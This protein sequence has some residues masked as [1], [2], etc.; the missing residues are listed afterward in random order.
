MATNSMKTH[1]KSMRTRHISLASFSDREDGSSRLGI[2]EGCILDECTRK[3]R[4]C[5][6]KLHIAFFLLLLLLLLLLPLVVLGKPNSC[7]SLP[8]DKGCP[9]WLCTQQ[10]SLLLVHTTPQWGRLLPC[11]MSR[12]WQWHCGWQL[13][14]RIPTRPTHRLE[15]QEQDTSPPP[16]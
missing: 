7:R 15:E 13:A 8:K 12:S 14:Q 10:H 2:C 16:G 5:C 3:G 9:L 11:S 4:N 6:S 1:P